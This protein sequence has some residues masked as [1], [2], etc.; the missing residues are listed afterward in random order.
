MPH[1][2]CPSIVQGRPTQKQALSNT[3]SGPVRF[4]KVNNNI[5][6]L[7][8]LQDT[9]KQPALAAFSL[10]P[11]DTTPPDTRYPASF[12]CVSCRGRRLGNRNKQQHVRRSIRLSALSRAA[13]GAPRC[14]GGLE[15]ARGEDSAGEEGTPGQTS[16][17]VIHWLGGFCVFMFPLGV[18]C[19]VPGHLFS[20][21][22]QCSLSLSRRR[23]CWVFETDFPWRQ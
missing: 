14:S 9:D 16:R 11:C 8:S 20:L 19:C 4:L 2:A 22:G 10:H 1:Q 3:G 18:A 21:R 17:F 5:T 6:P 23:G 12:R 15:R 7:S 13:E